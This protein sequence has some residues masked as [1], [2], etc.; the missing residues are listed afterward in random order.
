MLKI[1]WKK[2]SS[3]IF[4]ITREIENELLE[5]LKDNTEKKQSI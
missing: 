3:A 5:V 4:I 1:A 2:V